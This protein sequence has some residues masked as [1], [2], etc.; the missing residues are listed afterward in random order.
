MI[1][2]TVEQVEYAQEVFEEKRSYTDRFIGSTMRCHFPDAFD[3]AITSKK[4]AAA[5]REVLS[6]ESQR[7]VPK[8]KRTRKRI[9][10]TE[11]E[12]NRIIAHVNSAV[13]RVR[14]SEIGIPNKTGKQ[15]RQR[16]TE[17]LAPGIYKGEIDT[18]KLYP[19]LKKLAQKY[20]TKTSHQFTKMSTDSLAGG[21]PSLTL[22]NYLYSPNF[23]RYLLKNDEDNYASIYYD[24]LPQCAL[25]KLKQRHIEPPK[26]KSPP[27]AS[28]SEATIAPILP[29]TTRTQASVA[30]PAPPRLTTAAT[31]SRAYPYTRARAALP[32]PRPKLPSPPSIR[33][34]A[35]PKVLTDL[36]KYLD[37]GTSDPLEGLFPE[38]GDSSWIDTL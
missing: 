37:G 17:H 34:S 19:Q 24:A 10:W 33:P 30:I 15:I 32:T 27:G 7:K 36:K 35:P 5:V 3:R 38:L 21:L 20:M 18:K 31:T 13:A 23:F 6:R 4:I 16:Y 1:R 11:G 26:R 2:L 9:E 8:A 22:K 12:D 28:P 29:A 25:E 14:W